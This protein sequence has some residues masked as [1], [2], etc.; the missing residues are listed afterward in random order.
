[1]IQRTIRKQILDACKLN[2]VILIWGAR[3]VGK[4]TLVKS[5]IED[6]PDSKYFNCELLQNKEALETGNSELLFAS[7]GKYKYI[8]FDEAQSIRNIGNILK[9]IHDT[10]PEIKLI[11]TGS[12]SFHLKQVSGEPLTGRSREFIMSPLSFEEAVGNEELIT[13]NAK[14]DN[15]L[16]FG[17]YPEVY[18]NNEDFAIEELDNISSNYLFKDILQFENLKKPDLLYNLIKLLAFQIGSEV[19]LNELSNKLGVHVNTIKRYIELLEYNYVI[20]RL[21]ALSNNPRNEIGK[22]QK[23]YFYD[24]G[25]RN[26]L[27]R[28]FNPLNLRNDI[29]QLWENFVVSERIKMIHNYKKH[30]KTYF[31]RNYQKKEIDY[32]EEL[33]SNYELFECKYSYKKTINVPKDFQNNYSNFKFNIISRENYWKYLME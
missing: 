32:V 25:I 14:L 19:S 1:M 20:F 11:A 28:N 29:G 12:S 15:I 33:N 24:C 27:I 10:F 4:T 2:K 17:L 30:L 7:I 8:V 9:I 31:W 6:L 3:R 21:P 22:S 23:I 16:R 5:I 13:V 18:S 26:S